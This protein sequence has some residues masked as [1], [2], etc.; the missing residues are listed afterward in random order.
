MS[1][2]GYGDIACKTV[3]GKMFMVFFILGGL[4]RINLHQVLGRFLPFFVIRQ[5]LPV[6]FLKSP[7]LLVRGKNM[8]GNIKEKEEKGELK[9]LSNFRFFP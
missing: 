4:V 2:V 5:C 9:F 6:T 1:T 7:I 8:V 3:L